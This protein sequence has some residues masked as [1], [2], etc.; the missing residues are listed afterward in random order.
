MF[1][2]S[3]YT[4]SGDRNSQGRWLCSKFI[5]ETFQ[6][7]PE[8]ETSELVPKKEDWNEWQVP[9]MSKL[10]DSITEDTVSQLATTKKILKGE[11]GIYWLL[12]Y[13]Q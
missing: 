11:R 3:V 13:L 10:D 9:L 8:Q 12:E 2:G 5:L 6:Q 1:P 4:D 7:T